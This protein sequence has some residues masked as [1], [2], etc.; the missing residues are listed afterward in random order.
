MPSKIKPAP[1]KPRGPNSSCK[2]QLENTAKRKRNKCHQSIVNN[3]SN[4]NSYGNTNDSNSNYNNENNKEQHHTRHTSINRIH[5]V[6]YRSPLGGD[7]AL[8]DGLEEVAQGSGNDA[9]IEEL[10]WML[11]QRR[12]QLFTSKENNRWQILLNKVPFKMRFNLLS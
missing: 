11:E 6:D 3:D 5:R 1:A 12:E 9:K 2:I 7:G 8:P 10:Q 4:N